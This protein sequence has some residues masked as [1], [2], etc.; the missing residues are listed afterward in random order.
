MRHTTVVECAAHPAAAGKLLACLLVAVLGAAPG[1]A[2]RT[3][4]HLAQTAQNGESTQAS[5]ST[6]PSSEAC[7]NPADVLPGTR[8]EVEH[9]TTEGGVISISSQ[10]ETTGPRV[11]FANANPLIRRAQLTLEG[12]EA[13]PPGVAYHDIVDGNKIGYGADPVEGQSTRIVYVPPLAT[14]VSMLPGQTITQEYDVVLQNATLPSFQQ[15][16]Y[17]GRERIETPMGTFDSCHFS[18]L[19]GERGGDDTTLPRHDVWIAAEGP[20]RGQNLRS[21]TQAMGTNPEK[22]VEAISMDYRPATP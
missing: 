10:V 17:V 8:L 18:S 2:D 12:G 1:C 16:V 9:R 4:T 5:A 20:Y 11:Q 13:L 19:G 7:T 6:D 21:R 22:L 14:P 15:I 3:E